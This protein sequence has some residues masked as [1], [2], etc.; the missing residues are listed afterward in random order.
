MERWRGERE[1]EREKH[2]RARARGGW[3]M[4]QQTQ[5]KWCKKPGDRH[6]KSSLRSR[7]EKSGVRSWGIDGEKVV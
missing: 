3:A 5:K 1:R 7:T 4:Y 2:T 6:R